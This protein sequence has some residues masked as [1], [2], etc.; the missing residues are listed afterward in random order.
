MENEIFDKDENITLSEINENIKVEIEQSKKILFNEISENGD[1]YIGEINR[2]V[3]ANEVNKKKC[4][5]YIL[6]HKKNYFTIE[7]LTGYTYNDVLNIR[8]EL[9]AQRKSKFIDIFKFLNPSI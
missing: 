2:K 8:T 9:E 6:R 4:I 5:K 3:K 7:E 1:K